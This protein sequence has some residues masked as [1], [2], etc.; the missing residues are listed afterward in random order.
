MHIAP[1]TLLLFMMVLPL[2]SLNNSFPHCLFLLYFSLSSSFTSDLIFCSLISSLWF[3]IPL[4][5]MKWMGSL[6]INF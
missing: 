1:S 4:V 6:V 2:I 3:Y 5:I